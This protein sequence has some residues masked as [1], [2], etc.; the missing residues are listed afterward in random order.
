MKTIPLWRHR[1]IIWGHMCY[2]CVYL[3]HQLW[4]SSTLA[5]YG[6]KIIC[7]FVFNW[8]NLSYIWDG[9]NM[10]TWWQNYHF[11]AEHPF[12]TEAWI[13]WIIK[14]QRG[15]TS[16]EG[17]I[18]SKQSICGGWR[19]SRAD[20]TCQSKFPSLQKPCNQVPKLK[21]HTLCFSINP[22]S[23]FMPTHACKS[24]FS[25]HKTYIVMFKET[26]HPEF[27]EHTFAGDQV[28]EDIR[29][30]LQSHLTPIPRV[31]YRPINAKG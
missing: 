17:Y 3:K 23:L 25:T 10:S 28:L 31:S 19:M 6:L 12:S 30:F 22:F 2:H 1:C 21:T 16:G 11:G 20:S 15:T 8:R 5:L 14:Y 24:P 7:I 4:G 9:M 18:S 27:P 29:H 13:E 26:Q